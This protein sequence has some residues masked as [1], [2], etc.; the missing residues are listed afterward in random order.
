MALS[1]NVFLR[2]VSRS[3]NQCF[4]RNS[5]NVQSNITSL[6]MTCFAFLWWGVHLC[7]GAVYSHDMSWKEAFK[8]K[9]RLIPLQVN[10]PEGNRLRYFPSDNLQPS[11]PVSMQQKEDQA[12][13]WTRVGP[14]RVDG[15]C[16]FPQI[17]S[18]R[19]K[20]MYTWIQR[21]HCRK[22][23]VENGVYYAKLCKYSGQRS[24]TVHFLR[25]DWA[26][27]F[28]QRCW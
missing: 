13:D 6:P 12:I 19:E 8:Q 3:K 27:G 25:T 28:R 22:Q 18:E 2:E 9:T 14:R 5:N 23:A 10:P 1:Y 17:L 20:D 24:L 26:L 7:T 11:P 4:F 21:E 16:V 15:V